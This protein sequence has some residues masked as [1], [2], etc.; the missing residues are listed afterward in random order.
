MIEPYM[1]KY[2]DFT[3]M[4]CTLWPSSS[5]PG[6]LAAAAAAIERVRPSSTREHAAAPANGVSFSV[7]GKTKNTHTRARV[8]PYTPA[9]G[10]EP[11]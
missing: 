8:A 11:Y 9:T 10:S 4:L 6:C 1:I 3:N 7:T 5:S 2:V